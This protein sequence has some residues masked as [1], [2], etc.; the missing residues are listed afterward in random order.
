MEFVPCFLI[1]L[2]YAKLHFLSSYWV[3]ITSFPP[4]WGIPSFLP[5]GISH[6]FSLGRNNLFYSVLRNSLF[7]FRENFFECPDIEISRKVFFM[8][9][10]LSLWGSNWFTNPQSFLH[11][12]STKNKIYPTP[13]HKH[14][15]HPIQERNAQG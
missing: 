8:K 1:N 13:T 9:S 4:H 14:F 6:F 11:I 7:S 3:E 10:K 5:G 2:T 15:L 12:K